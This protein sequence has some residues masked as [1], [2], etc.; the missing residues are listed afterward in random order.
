MRLTFTTT[1]ISQPSFQCCFWFLAEQELSQALSF[2]V[3]YVLRKTKAL[4]KGGN[5][6]MEGY[7]KPS[8]LT[9][10]HTVSDDA[11]PIYCRA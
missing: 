3:S 7:E 9:L 10:I 2:I 1:S 8:L 4:W 5:R 6:T 11:L